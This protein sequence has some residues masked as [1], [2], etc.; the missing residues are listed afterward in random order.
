MVFVE[1]IAGLPGSS[2]LVRTQGYLRTANDREILRIVHIVGGL[3]AVE[4]DRV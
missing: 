2:A 1:V 3:A 4:L